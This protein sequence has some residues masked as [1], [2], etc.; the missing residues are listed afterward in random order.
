MQIVKQILLLVPLEIVDIL[1]ILTNKAKS[2]L[3]RASQSPWMRRYLTD[4]IQQIGTIVCGP[5]SN[6]GVCGLFE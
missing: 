4:C 3:I 6:C 1:G 2:R 5:V